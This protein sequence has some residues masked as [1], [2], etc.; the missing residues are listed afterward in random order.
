MDEIVGE[1]EIPHEGIGKPLQLVFPPLPVNLWR[2]LPEVP[3]EKIGSGLNKKVRA[4]TSSQLSESQRNGP[5]SH[6][7]LISDP[8]HMTYFFLFFFFLI[9]STSHAVMVFRC[10]LYATRLG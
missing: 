2:P 8:H 7:E 4:F 6:K 9:I 1:T 5:N 10:I 3:A